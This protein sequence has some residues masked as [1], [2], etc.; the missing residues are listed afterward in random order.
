[1]LHYNLMQAYGRDLREEPIHKRHLHL[2]ELLIPRKQSWCAGTGIGRL[3]QRR[4]LVV[5][6][7]DHR[8][9]RILGVRDADDD[10]RGCTGIR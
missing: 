3:S 2:C 10:F 6:H 1:M 7:A 8:F 9:F 4:E 5:E